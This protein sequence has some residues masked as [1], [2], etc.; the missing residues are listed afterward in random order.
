[1]NSSLAENPVAERARIAELNKKVARL[2]E[3]YVLEEIAGDLHQK[4]KQ[5]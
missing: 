2:E 3:R 1:M 4:Y 5:S